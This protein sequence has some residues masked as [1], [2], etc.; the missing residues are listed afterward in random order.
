MLGDDPNLLAQ[1]LQKRFPQ[2]VLAGGDAQ[3]EQWV[4]RVV[5]FVDA[6]QLGLDLPL[7]VRGTVFQQRVWQAL[8][9]IP[10]G[11]TASYA[12]IAQKIGAPKLRVR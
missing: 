12:E 8:C 2:A 6:P 5:G 10:L 4:A 9:E 7:D 1:D 3:F 11:S